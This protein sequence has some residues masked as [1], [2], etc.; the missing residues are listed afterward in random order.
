MWDS[1]F[2]DQ[3]GNIYNSCHSKLGI[4]GKIY[5]QD[6]LNIW[7][8]CLHCFDCCT[9]LSKRQKQES[10]DI[11]INNQSYSKKYPARIWILY[12]L[13][14]NLTNSSRTLTVR[15]LIHFAPLLHPY[16]SVV[17]S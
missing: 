14:C 15:S 1:V 11:I 7:D 10:K 9:I 12:G 13:R 16:P 8:K 2:I 17:T 4:I 6:L 5:K 3:K